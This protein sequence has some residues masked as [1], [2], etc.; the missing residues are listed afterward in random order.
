MN[1]APGRKAFTLIEL[2][3]VIAIIAILAAIL[4]PVF[5]QAKSAAKKTA[6]MSNAKQVGLTY[7]LYVADFDDRLPAK[8]Y[9]DHTTRWPLYLMPTYAKNRDIVFCPAT[10]DDRKIFGPSMQDYMYGLTPGYG[11]N[12]WYLSA[13]PEPAAG[14]VLV[15]RV[16]TEIE[17]PSET[18]M[19]AESTFIDGSVQPKFGYFYVLPPSRWLGSP[20]LTWES[21]GYVWPRHNNRATT[22]FPDSHV[23]TLPVSGG[24]GTLAD[25]QIWDIQ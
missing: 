25:E 11:L 2:L 18:V 12:F 17:R 1:L 5:A 15:G 16:M 10:N 13:N 24:K 21:F 3:V 14:E 9:N 19:L 22:I 20:P 23:K 6:C 4:F 8:Y 7:S